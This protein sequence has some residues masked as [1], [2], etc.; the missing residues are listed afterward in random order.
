VSGQIHVP[1]A[2]LPQKLPSVAI[3]QEAG[4][5]GCCVEGKTSYHC[6]EL[7]SDFSA[8]HPVPCHYTD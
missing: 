8:L 6:Q 5:S 7:N 2:L 1:A 4:C 3:G